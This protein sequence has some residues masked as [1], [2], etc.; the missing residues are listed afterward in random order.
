MEYRWLEERIGYSFRDEGLLTKALTHSSFS[1]D[2]NERLEFLGDAVLGLIITEALFQHFPDRPE[3]ELS[4]MRAGIVCGENLYGVGRALG[5]GE[6][7]RLGSG[8]ASSGGRERASNLADAVEALVAAM[9]LDGGLDAC[10]S[11]TLNFFQAHIADSGNLA[12]RDPKTRLQEYVQSIQK[13]LPVYRL[14]ER[15]G[16]EHNASFRVVCEIDALSL[17]AE[18]EGG[19]L[20]KAGQAAAAA[21]LAI[22]G[23]QSCAE[24]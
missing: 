17:R 18:A 24:K 14:M 23:D 8:E 9:Y 15:T 12:E 2:H 20:K 5:L 21:V 22:L 16:E 1:S 19:S 4:R 6:A 10:R 11:P 3:G 7:M 13:P